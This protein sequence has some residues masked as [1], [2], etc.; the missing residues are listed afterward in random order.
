VAGFRDDQAYVWA[1][2]SASLPEPC[3]TLKFN[4]RVIPSS[5]PQTSETSW[6]H[7]DFVA[8]L[9]TFFTVPAAYDFGSF[10][11]ATIA[12]A[13]I[14][15]YTA[16]AIPGWANSVLI[17]GMRTGAVYRLKLGAD[18]TRVSG[19]PIE[20]FKAADRYRDLAISP[21][22]RRIFLVTDSFGTTADETGQ[23]TETLANP[24][25]LLEFTYSGSPKPPGRA[26]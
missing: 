9:A 22:G 10:G 23:R 5:V 3:Q 13:G 6:E 1:N 25:A 18:G 17:T 26:Q 20:Y 12:P 19:S 14:D 24:G 15:V 7:R 21:D 2:W 16:G 8:P 4:T 11:N